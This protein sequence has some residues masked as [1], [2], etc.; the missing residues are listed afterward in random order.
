MFK[1]KLA[2]IGEIFSVLALLVLLFYLL[3]SDL[4]VPGPF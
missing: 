1:D 4:T 3:V 2:W